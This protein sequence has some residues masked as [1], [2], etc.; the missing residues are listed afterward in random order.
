MINQQTLIEAGIPDTRISSLLEACDSLHSA[1]A[2]I[3]PNNRKILE[4]AF[5]EILK[6]AQQFGQGCPFSDNL[7]A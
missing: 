1:V 5:P 7:E 4:G 2:F 6:V 3:S